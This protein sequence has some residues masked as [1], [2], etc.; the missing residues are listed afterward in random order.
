[1]IWKQVHSSVTVSSVASSRSAGSAEYFPL[2]G[3]IPTSPLLVSPRVS[4][5]QSSQLP[6]QVFG[7]TV[8][9]KK[10][11]PLGVLDISVLGRLLLSLSFFY[12]TEKALL[13]YVK[14]LHTSPM[15]A[16]SGL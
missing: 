11:G 15:A 13:S 5:S 4:V 7:V 9:V 14:A 10:N 1:M 12:S 8:S 6:E 3:R 16:P 2:C